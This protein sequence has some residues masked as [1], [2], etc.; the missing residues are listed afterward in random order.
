M[1]G[2]S[3]RVGAWAMM[4]VAMLAVGGC[5]SQS[6]PAQVDPARACVDA[7]DALLAAADDP[8]PQVRTNAIEALAATEGAAAGAIFAQSL[9]DSHAP[10]QDAALMAIGD[11]R[12]VPAK[13]LLT[14]LAKANELPPKLLIALAYALHRLGDDAYMKQLGRLLYDTDP[15]V[16]AKVAMVM[17][18]MGEPSARGPLQ[19]IQRDDRDPVVQLQVVEALARLGDERCMSLL[20]AFT[21]SQY[22]EDRIIAVQAM[23]YLN[24]QRSVYVLRGVLGH[25]Q[26]DPVVR[27]AAAASLGRLNRAEGYEL[28]AQAA[29]D[30]RA[31]LQRYRGSSVEVTREEVVNLQ[32]IA[33]LALGQMGNPAAVGVLHPLLRSPEGAVRVAAG[34]AILQLLPGYRPPARPSPPEVPDV[35]RPPPPTTT[36]RPKLYSAGGKD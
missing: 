16:R 12:Y 8:S 22:I 31:A 27:V 4:S 5:G 30:P 10:V 21:K 24:T 20:E 14:E 35:V 28:A 36:S 19:T 25:V 2:R 9:K 32:T 13:P 18:K 29:A 3:V 33:A 17:G 6:T 7:R 11:V 15:W 1:K 26:Q 34:Q 23:G